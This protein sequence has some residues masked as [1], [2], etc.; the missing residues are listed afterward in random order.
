M[1]PPPKATFASLS[2][3]YVDLYGCFFVGL[4]PRAV[5]HA[6]RA[7]VCDIGIAPPAR[8]CPGLLMVH[9]QIPG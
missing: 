9:N 6:S 7:P 8:H 2:S 1:T 4:A 3:R 5:H